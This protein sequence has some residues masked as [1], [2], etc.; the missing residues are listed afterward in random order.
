MQ[1][2]FLAVK[3][4]LRQSVL[5]AGLVTLVSL[6]SLL[7][8]YTQPSYAALGR[9]QQ[10]SPEEEFERAQSSESPDVREEAYDAATKEAKN[11][12]SEEKAYEENLEAYKEENP[13]GGLVEGAKGLVE[14]ITGGGSSGGEL[15]TP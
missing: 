13:G 4:I 6:S 5:I 9:T 3:Q 1:R 8:F 10:V 12:G 14:K 11:L 7:I 2:I 15:T